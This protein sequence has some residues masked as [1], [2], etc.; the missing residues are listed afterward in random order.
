MFYF[1]PFIGY[2]ATSFLT[3]HFSADDFYSK[4][5]GSVKEMQKKKNFR[6]EKTL[7]IFQSVSEQ[8]SKST[9]DRREEDWSSTVEF[10]LLR[11]KKKRGTSLFGECHREEAQ[12]GVATVT[13][14]KT[15][16]PFICCSVEDDKTIKKNKQTRACP[17]RPIVSHFISHEG[18]RWARGLVLHPAPVIPPTLH[19]LGTWLSL[20]FF[21][22][23]RVAG[24]P[25]NLGLGLLAPWG[26]GVLLRHPHVNPPPHA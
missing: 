13:F 25:A 24:C 26:L 12:A 21:W 4:L 18:W 6:Q 16:K 7:H 20:G 2:T 19:W 5:F 15:G 8:Q 14:H 10:K 11:R 17:A 9:H 22:F 23:W 3:R 1:S